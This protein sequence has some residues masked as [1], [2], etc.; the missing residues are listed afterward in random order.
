MQDNN[1]KDK[2]SKAKQIVPHLDSRHCRQVPIIRP[3]RP[4]NKLTHFILFQIIKL[5]ICLLL[6]I[7]SAS[8][9]KELPGIHEKL[10][11]E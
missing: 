1:R 2:N 6:I 8:D 4:I 10:K 3:L 5:A 9:I 7:T 11:T